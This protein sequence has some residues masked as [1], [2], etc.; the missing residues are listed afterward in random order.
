MSLRRAIA[1][2][3]ASSIAIEQP[4]R[5]R[6]TRMS[7]LVRHWYLVLG[8]A[9]LSGTTTGTLTAQTAPAPPISDNSFLI[10]EAYNQESGVVERFGAVPQRLEHYIERRGR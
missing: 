8:A 9:V 6:G 5:I 3:H 7:V 10:E 2:H 1:T 4:T